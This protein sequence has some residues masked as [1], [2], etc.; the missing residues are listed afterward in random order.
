MPPADVQNPPP[1]LTEWVGQLFQHADMLRM[2]HCQSLDDKNLGLGWL[3][4]GLARV[5]RP[6]KV[7]VIGSYRGFVPLV[8]G[9][10]LADNDEGGKV[11]FIDPSLVDDFWKDAAAVQAHFAS[12]GVTNICHFLA[13]TQQFVESE[14]YRSLEDIGMVFIDGFHSEE[15]ACFDYEAFRDKL[16]A[17]GVAL[18]HDSIRIRRSG[19]Y[20]RSKPY[21]HRVKCYMDALKRD[22]ALQIFDVPFGDGVTLVRRVSD[23]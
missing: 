14:T 18:F 19:I 4:Y 21:D 2:G 1:P 17:D 22:R 10:A 3:Y 16:T 8:L 5:I 7:V 9:K 20:D 15:Q 13:T 6:P 12:F 11:Y 23:E